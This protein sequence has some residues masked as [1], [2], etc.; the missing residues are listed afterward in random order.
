MDK[1]IFDGSIIMLFVVMVCEV[2]G[3][4]SWNHLEDFIFKDMHLCYFKCLPDMYLGYIISFPVALLLK[5]KADNESLLRDWPTQSTSEECLL[6]QN[7]LFKLECHP[8]IPHFG[9]RINY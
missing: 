4:A 5:Q 3:R 1:D 2:N 9:Q 8:K 6:P 7:I